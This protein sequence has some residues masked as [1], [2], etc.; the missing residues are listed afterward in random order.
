MIYTETINICKQAKEHNPKNH[1]THMHWAFAN[2]KLG[3]VVKSIKKIRKGV[4]KMP[5]NADNWIVWGLIL[6]TA[7]QYKSAKHKFRKALKIDP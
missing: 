5:Y 7:G 4:T 3:N 1:N 6:R 2:F